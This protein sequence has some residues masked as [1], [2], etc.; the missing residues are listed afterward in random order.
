[1]LALAVFGSC[2]FLEY[3]LAHLSGRQAHDYWDWK[4]IYIRCG[5]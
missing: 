2:I 4:D 5:I 3:R 1:M